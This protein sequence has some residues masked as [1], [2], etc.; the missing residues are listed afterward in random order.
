MLKRMYLGRTPMARHGFPVHHGCTTAVEV[1]NVFT[2]QE[3]DAQ[4]ILQ[5]STG[6]VDGPCAGFLSRQIPRRDPRNFG[7][8][9]LAVLTPFRDDPLIL[10]VEGASVRV[11]VG[12]Y[13]VVNPNEGATP[14][15]DHPFS[16]IMVTLFQPV[17]RDAREAVG[18]SKSAGPFDFDRAVRPMKDPLLEAV[19]RLVDHGQATISR[20]EEPW[21][22]LEAYLAALQVV[23]ALWKTHPSQLRDRMEQRGY[24]PTGDHRLDRALEYLRGHVKDRCPNAVVAAAAGVSAPQ[25]YRL[26]QDRLGCSPQEFLRRLRVD[27]AERYLQEEGRSPSSLAEAAKAV[28]LGRPQTLKEAFLAVRGHG[29]AE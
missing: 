9:G 12:S 21:A 10:R 27:M 13:V 23:A 24:R 5:V 22:P 16:A 11:P 14:D 20:E 19:K 26:F 2:S 3:D 4:A 28:G 1:F 18:I 8:Y 25:L 15:P 7:S 17:L 29:L 6:A